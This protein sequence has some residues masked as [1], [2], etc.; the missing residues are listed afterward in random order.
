MQR[1]LNEMPLLIQP[2]HSE[3]NNRN[4]CTLFADRIQ[5]LGGTD[6]LHCQQTASRGQ[7]VAATMHHIL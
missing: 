5:F 4:S 6:A 1:N 2:W 7:Q 3:R